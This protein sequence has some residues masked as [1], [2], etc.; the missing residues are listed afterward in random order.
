MH[1]LCLSFHTYNSTTITT[2]RSGRRGGKKEKKAYR[3]NFSYKGTN[4]YKKKHYNRILLFSSA[5]SHNQPLFRKLYINHKYTKQAYLAN[6]K[7]PIPQ[8]P[9]QT[10]VRIAYKPL[11]PQLYIVCLPRCLSTLCKSSTLNVVDSNNVYMQILKNVGKSMVFQKW[12]LRQII[13]LFNCLLLTRWPGWIS[14]EYTPTACA[15]AD[16]PPR[17]ALERGLV[18]V[19]V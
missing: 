18:G 7:K 12:K 9:R 10:R 15:G 5:P 4:L 6:I 1:K 11:S 2:D 13:I 3:V 17:P 14:I 19:G 16:K 8:T